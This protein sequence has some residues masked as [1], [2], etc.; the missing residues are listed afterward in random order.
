[1]AFEIRGL[2]IAF[3]AGEDLSDAQYKF[4]A[5]NS[6]GEATLSNATDYP[7]GIL[8]N[9]PESGEAASVR[10]EGFSKLAM[11]STGINGVTGVA[12]GTWVSSDAN[13]LGTGETGTGWDFKYTKGRVVDGTDGTS[14]NQLSTVEIISANPS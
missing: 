10:V 12:I 13:A 2:D 14:V 1:M 11:G 5:L 8:Q 4:I 7:I 9:D 3:D 6:D